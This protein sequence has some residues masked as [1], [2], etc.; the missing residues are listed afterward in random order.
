MV[1]MPISRAL[2]KAE[3]RF[4]ELPDVEMPISPSPA[5][6]CA[7]IWRTNTCSKPTSLPTAEIIA[8]SATR[9]I[10]AKAGRPAVIG[11]TNSTATWEAS[12]LDPPLPM[13]NRRPPLR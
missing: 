10:A 11:C 13:V 8:R 1:A 9:L 3:I 12:Q 4:A 2:A 5:F 7:T 6:P